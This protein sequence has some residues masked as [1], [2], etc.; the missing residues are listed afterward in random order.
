MVRKAIPKNKAATGKQA[1]FDAVFSR[2]RSILERYAQKNMRVKHDRQEYYEIETTYP[3][4]QHKSVMFGAVRVGKSYV[5][6][7]LMPLYMN[8]T[9]T[10]KVSP[11]LK[12]RQQ[13]KAC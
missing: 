4:L 7:H 6:Y 1:D 13:G 3:V 11:E 2:L 8:Q 9:L 10:N 12:R 5:S